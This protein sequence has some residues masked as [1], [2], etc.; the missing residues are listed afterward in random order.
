MRVRDVMT[1]EVVTAMPDDRAWTAGET[2]ARLEITGM[3]VIARDR[4]VVGMITEIE[5]I[6]AA[7]EGRDLRA[8]TVADLM[9]RKPACTTPEMD[10]A[11]AAALMTE[12]HVR[13]LPVCRDGR[14]VG[15][16]SLSDLLRALLGSAL[17][18]PAPPA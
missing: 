17:Q 8:L 16:V 14:L 2:L 11:A 4:R 1:S 10:V 9:E 12:R 15:L 6:R 5:I 3:P 18:A 13:W 7:M